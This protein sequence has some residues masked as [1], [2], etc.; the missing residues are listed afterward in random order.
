MIGNDILIKWQKPQCRAMYPDSG[1]GPGE[2]TKDLIPCT[3]SP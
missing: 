3:P 1:S 2:F